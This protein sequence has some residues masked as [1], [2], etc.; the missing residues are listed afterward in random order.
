MKKNI[1]AIIFLT[2]VLILTACSNTE[3]NVSSGD[4]YTDYKDY[5]K[6]SM[7]SIVGEVVPFMSNEEYTL[8]FNRDGF[9]MNVIGATSPTIL[10]IEFFS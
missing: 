4:K 9:I 2:L 5:E 10:T 3:T 1:F 7:V 8:E 6:N